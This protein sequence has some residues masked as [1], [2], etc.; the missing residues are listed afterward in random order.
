MNTARSTL[1]EVPW[2]VGPAALERHDVVNDVAGAGTRGLA[3]RGAWWWCSKSRL[4]VSLRL[5]LPWL[6][7][8][9]L[10]A[11]G[12]GVCSDVVR[13]VRA[14]WLAGADGWLL[15]GALRVYGAT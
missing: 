6:S 14:P 8:V 7:R 12:V 10:T 5:I 1:I 3:G 2:I 15:W 4:A 11:R 13:E 9:T